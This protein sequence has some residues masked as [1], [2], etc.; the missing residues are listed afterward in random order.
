MVRQ[1]D[2]RRSIYWASLLWTRLCHNRS[3]SHLGLLCCPIWG[4]CVLEQLFPLHAALQA[5]RYYQLKFHTPDN[6]I[7]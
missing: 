6:K 7:S 2:K 5:E 3:S 4:C 1:E